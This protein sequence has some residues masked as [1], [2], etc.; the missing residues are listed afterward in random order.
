[1]MMYLDEARIRGLLRWPELIT[2]MEGALAAFSQGRTIQ[3]VR[4]ML[5]IEEGKRYLAVMPAVTE[6]AMG[7]KL[8]S[9]YKLVRPSGPGWKPIEK[10]AGES[11][12]SDSNTEPKG[13]KPT[14]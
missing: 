4:D 12:D 11:L 5:T 10:L 7:A 14:L 9:F 2:A 6:A 1:M 13:P 8:V 3:P